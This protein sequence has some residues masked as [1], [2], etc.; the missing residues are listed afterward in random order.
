MVRILLS[1]GIILTV[2]IGAMNASSAFFSDYES[3]TGNSLTAGAVDLKVAN[4][5]Y[6][7][8][9]FSSGTTWSLTDLTD[10]K[11]F[12]FTDVKPGDVGID[13]IG[14]KIEGN[15]S[16]ACAD[17]HISKNDD[18]G[19]NE[20]ELT[21]GDIPD[22]SGDNF[23][24]ELA[25]TIY[26]AIWRDDGDSVLEDNETVLTQGTAANILRDVT[27]PLADST[28]NTLGEPN[29]SPMTGDTLYH[30]AKS[31]CFG[32]M[33]IA[34]LGQ[35]G[36][37]DARTPTGPEGPGIS[38]SGANAGNK[39]QTDLLTG[40]IS[41]SVVQTRSNPNFICGQDP[42][43]TPPASCE[44]VYGSSVVSSAQGTLKNGLPI[45]D[46]L[47]TNPANAL[48][49]PDNQFFSIGKNGNITLSFASP[50]SNL[51]G[52]D[53]TIRV[54]EITNGRDTYPEEKA[55][56]EVSQDGSTYIPIAQRA[57]SEPGGG[58][59]GITNIDFS[60]TGLPDIQYVKL[61]D[62]TNY[63][64]HADTADGY[65]LD[66]IRGNCVAE[67]SPLR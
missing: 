34:P 43:P 32:D 33:T 15:D 66:A 50:I 11:F 24:G 19:S 31:W 23:D 60:G 8:G 9:Q 14:L 40:D 6:Y 45:T 17:I 10:E 37:S 26:F 64:P 61:F 35:D 5:S 4:T 57:S 18:N 7:N 63:A 2:F 52:Y 38:C 1:L 41:F 62:D 46:S 53:L 54:H 42:T 28:I 29:G 48:G 27:W 30:I 47:R 58:G 67:E 13:V 65:D 21:D 20:P 55:R 44:P 56:V 16:W 36:K 3:T 51:L 12:N 22:N 49:V 25:Q 39:T 59:D